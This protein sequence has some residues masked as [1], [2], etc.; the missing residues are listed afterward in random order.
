MRVVRSYGPVVPGEALAEYDQLMAK[1]GELEQLEA[2]HSRLALVDC[3]LTLAGMHERSRR[4]S[5]S[6]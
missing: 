6:T 5:A 2:A 1:I 3:E 4:S